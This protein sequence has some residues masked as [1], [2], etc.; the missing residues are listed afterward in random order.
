MRHD[1]PILL[2]LTMVIL[3]ACNSGYYIRMNPN[4]GIVPTETGEPLPTGTK[5]VSGHL[6]QTYGN[7]DLEHR[8]RSDGGIDNV[9][10]GDKILNTR[11]TRIAVHASMQSSLVE[12]VGIGLTYSSGERGFGQDRMFSD[13]WTLILDNTRYWAQDDSITHISFYHAV[14][15]SMMS[16]SFYDLNTD[17]LTQTKQALAID[18]FAAWLWHQRISRQTGIRIGL[19]APLTIND[20]TYLRG[21]LTSGMVFR[22]SDRFHLNLSGS[23]Y[24]EAV[25][26]RWSGTR[27]GIFPVVY[28][29]FGTF[30]SKRLNSS[31]FVDVNI[32]F[33]YLF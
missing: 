16:K 24:S 17:R 13:L 2:V 30:G 32:G 29:V 4:Q 22:F 6:S 10:R 15:A 28:P 18:Y 7:D 27:A 14:G 3:S 31:S 20:P 23:Y 5:G 9:Q 19:V 33:R 11:S 1:F 12:R 25:P 21:G 26:I 8:S